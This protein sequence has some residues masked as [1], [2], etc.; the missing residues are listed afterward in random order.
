[1]GRQ[2]LAK[3]QGDTGGLIVRSLR[4]QASGRKEKKALE[5]LRPSLLKRAQ[6]KWEERCLGLVLQ[7]PG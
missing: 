6:G 1:M 2:P 3:A 5:N 7:W 4:T